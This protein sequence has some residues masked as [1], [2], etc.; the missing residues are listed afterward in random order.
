MPT[1]SRISLA[2][3]FEGVLDESGDVLFVFDDEY[4]VSGHV[5]ATSVP[6]GRFTSMSK[7]LNVG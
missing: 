6:A 3:T 2:A 1:I 7:V 5:G 4:A